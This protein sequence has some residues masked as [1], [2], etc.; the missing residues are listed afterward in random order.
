M[1][2]HWL[3]P[4]PAVKAVGPLQLAPMAELRIHVTR[5]HA[6]CFVLAK[7]SHARAR[8][9]IAAVRGVPTK[10]QLVRPTAAPYFRTLGATS[11]CRARPPIE[12]LADQVRGFCEELE[13]NGGVEDWQVRQAD[14][15]LRIL[16][17]RE[18][19]QTHRVASAAGQHGR[20]RARVYESLCGTGA[21]ADTFE[22]APLFVSHGMHV[23]GL[24]AAVPRLRR[25]AAGSSQSDLGWRPRSVR[26][27]L[28]HLAVRQHVSASTQNQAFCAILFLCREVLG[29][30]VESLSPGVRAKR[31]ERLPVVLSKPETIALLDA[32]VRDAALDG[33]AHLRRRAARLGVLRASDQGISTLTRGSW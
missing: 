20:R 14:Q 1:R 2:L 31:G 12:P 18:F 11:S 29:V 25:P 16:V 9:I 22:D 28:A 10:A 4:P 3:T 7:V 24:G 30:D 5:W 8:V 26:D 27:Y 33:A 21:A 32:D 13:R 15:A 17:L 6:R 23:R 19:P